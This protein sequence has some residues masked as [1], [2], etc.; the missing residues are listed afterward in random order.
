MSTM[1]KPLAALAALSLSLS[2]ACSRPAPRVAEGNDHTETS[3]SAQSKSA[4]ETTPTA[5]E[6]GRQSEPAK[7]ESASATTHKPLVQAE[8]DLD[9]KPGPEQLVLYSDR[10]LVAGK[11]KG[12]A[13]LTSAGEFW[14]NERASL[15][16]V[17]LGRGVRAVL[18][19]LPT[20]DEED[21][22]SRFQLFR[23]VA[24]K[25]ERILDIS[26]G[27]ASPHRLRFPGDG[28]ARFVEAPEQACA[29][30]GAEARAI[31][32]YEV[33]YELA[34]TTMIERPRKDVV[35]RTSCAEARLADG[36]L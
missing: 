12:T 19:A 28:T 23:L 17:L 9:G 7:T 2:S 30:R 20:L 8:E 6:R 3:A 26:P 5:R 36:E 21:P 1:L 32:L 29:Q 18:V 11:A 4:P 14:I 16:V 22:P 25:L 35:R 27:F 13:E 10:T 24:D 15:R 34:D 31:P 33:V